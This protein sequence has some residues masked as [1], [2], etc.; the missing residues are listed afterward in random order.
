MNQPYELIY[1]HTYSVYDSNQ[2]K[3]FK[4]MLKHIKATHPSGVILSVATDSFFDGDGL[5]YSVTATVEAL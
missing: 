5:Y 3:A 4:K 1:T 2:H